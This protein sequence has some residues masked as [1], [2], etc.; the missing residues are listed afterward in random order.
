MSDSWKSIENYT[1][2]TMPSVT[3]NTDKHD[4]W[5]LS[6]M[7]LELIETLN[8][9]NNRIANLESEMDV[10]IR[11]VNK[12]HVDIQKIIT[13]IDDLERRAVENWLDEDGRG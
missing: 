4:N 7:V 6:T 10:K 2:Q 12:A 11:D 9:L 8:H 5:P 3:G 1:T 13:R